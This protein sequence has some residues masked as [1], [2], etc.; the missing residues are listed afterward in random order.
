MLAKTHFLIK[1]NALTLEKMCLKL[2]LKNKECLLRISID[3]TL[4]SIFL[5]TIPNRE[6]EKIIKNELCNC[7]TLL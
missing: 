7:I 1:Y 3:K 4:L 2:L 5:I 6:Y